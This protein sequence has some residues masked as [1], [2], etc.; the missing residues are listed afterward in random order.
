MLASAHLVC[1]WKE[2]L[3]MVP[4]WPGTC[5]VAYHAGKTANGRFLALEI[6]EA[7]DEQKFQQTWTRAIKIVRLVC[8][9]WEWPLT[10]DYIWSHQKVGQEWSETDHQ[11]PIP[12]FDRW[13][14][15][16]GGFL[17]GVVHS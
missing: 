2:T 16:W 13:R 7:L 9:I 8:Q 17:A 12:Y 6:C 11:D 5:E 14:R 4:C 3:V 10:G 1:D 15:T